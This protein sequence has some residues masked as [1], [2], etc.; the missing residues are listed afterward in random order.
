MGVEMT[1]QRRPPFWRRQFYVHAIQKTFAIYFGVYLF[2]YSLLVFGLALFV[3]HLIT[4]LKLYLPLPIE[5]RAM[6][7]SQFLALA[8][9]VGP[10][11]VAIIIGSALFSIYLTHRLAG[12]LYRFEQHANALAQ[13]DL[14]IRIKL[15]RGDELQ[16]LASMI[17]KTVTQMDTALGEIVHLQVTR[18][19]ALQAI[20]VRLKTRPGSDPESLHDLEL[21]LKAGQQINSVLNRFRISPRS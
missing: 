17:N 18:E 19:A 16:E 1:V 15:R 9:T 6:A 20:I 12:P 5:Q 11:L 7:A 14:S 10:A 8:E 4:A 3:P 2:A 21:M 13:G